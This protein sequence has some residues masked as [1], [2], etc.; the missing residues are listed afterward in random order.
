MIYC[1][2]LTSAGIHLAYLLTDDTSSPSNRQHLTYDVCLEDKKVDY[3]N[4]SVLYCVQQLCTLILVN[5]G[6]LI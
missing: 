3:L 1:P 2:R 5:Q 6:L 4:C